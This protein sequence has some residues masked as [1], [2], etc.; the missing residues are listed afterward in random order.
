MNTRTYQ[1]ILMGLILIFLGSPLIHS[2]ASDLSLEPLPPPR[3]DR[4]KPLM[5]CLKERSSSR[6]FASRT[7]D[8]AQVSDLLWAAFGVNRQESGKRTAPSTVNA[9]SV[10][11]YLVTA[12]GV[13]LYDAERHAL[14]PLHDRDVR[15]VTGGQ[16][17]VRQAPVSL[18]FVAEFD[19]LDRFPESERRFYTA[20]D[21]GFISQN[22]Y[23]FSASENLAT[24]VHALSDQESLREALQLSPT[25]KPLLAQCVGY[26]ASDTP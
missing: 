25:Q 13:F 3:L 1:V 22:V 11:V 8:R 5:Q 10:D 14:K 23:L 21:V 26:P 4:G 16:A 20:A 19:R 15:F 12:E 18:V 2:Y 9:R 7:L 24:V 6:E 17:Y